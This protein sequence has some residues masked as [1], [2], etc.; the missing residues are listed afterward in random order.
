MSDLEFIALNITVEYMLINFELQLFGCI[1]GTD[2]EEKIERSVYNKRKRKLFSYIEK[3][4]KNLSEKFP[5]FTNVFIVDSTPIEIC[6]SR[7]ANR[8]EICSTDEI[9]PA[10]GYCAAQ[11]NKIFWI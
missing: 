4:R 5:H 7:R 1:S 2:L 9:Q 8:S 6:K 10:F 11:K 3:I